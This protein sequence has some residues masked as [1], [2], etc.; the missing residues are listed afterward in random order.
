M[1]KILK[2]RLFFF[3]T[4]IDNAVLYLKLLLPNKSQSRQSIDTNNPNNYNVIKL[5][6]FVCLI[7]VT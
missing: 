4:M 1:L 2:F 3:F 5:A 6:F 7:R